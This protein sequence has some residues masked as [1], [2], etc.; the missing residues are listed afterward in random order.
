MPPVAAEILRRI[1]PNMLIAN[2]GNLVVGIEDCDDP[3]HRIYRL[4]YRSTA[5]GAHA[6][7]VCVSNPWDRDDPTAG[8]SADRGHISEGGL[9]RL[10]PGVEAVLGVGGV[11]LVENSPFHVEEAVI[12]ARYWVAAFSCRYVFE[13]LQQMKEN[14]P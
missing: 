8:M 6:I 3:E 2:E 7:A 9:I 10:G 11:P 12:R 1:N 5:D 14:R 13:E 4:E